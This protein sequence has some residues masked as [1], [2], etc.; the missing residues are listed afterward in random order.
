MRVEVTSGLLLESCIEK[1]TTSLQLKRHRSTVE[2]NSSN[3]FESSSSVKELLDSVHNTNTCHTHYAIHILFL[4][5]ILLYSS[6]PSLPSPILPFLSPSSLSFLLLFSHFPLYS[7]SPT[8]PLSSLP[9]HSISPLPTL[10]P[11]LSPLPRTRRRSHS[12]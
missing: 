2:S 7:L 3:I 1:V 12:L 9:S 4:M 8:S 6:S 11:P 5:L 10:S